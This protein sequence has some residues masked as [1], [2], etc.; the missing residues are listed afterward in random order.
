MSGAELA[1]RYRNDQADDENLAWAMFYADDSG[2]DRLTNLAG[3]LALAAFGL[4]AEVAS[5]GEKTLEAFLDDLERAGDDE[6]HKLM[7]ATIRGMLD[8]RG[9][10]V[11]GRTLAQD[12]ARFL[13]LL[14]AL[15]SYCGTSILALQAIGTPAE[16]TLDDLE[17]ALRDAG[18][19][20]EPAATS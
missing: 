2:T 15:T 17:D 9:V 1:A 10:E 6:V 3:G 14:L 12:Q 19:E 5:R 4:S 13:D 7:V 18:D 20:A 16:T 8:D 11:M